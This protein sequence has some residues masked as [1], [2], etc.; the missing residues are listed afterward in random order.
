MAKEAYYHENIIEIALSI[1]EEPEIISK[2]AET[3]SDI[4]NKEYE[5]IQ[6]F[7]DDVNLRIQEFEENPEGILTTQLLVP[8]GTDIIVN[9]LISSFIINTPFIINTS[10]EDAERFV[11]YIQECINRYQKGTPLPAF[12]YWLL[13]EIADIHFDNLFY[14]GRVKTFLGKVTFCITIIGVT[15]GTRASMY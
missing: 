1:Y 13:K 5:K 7:E 2:K 3:L 11:W 14:L 4:Y 12:P 15:V 8:G 10:D 9:M 6:K